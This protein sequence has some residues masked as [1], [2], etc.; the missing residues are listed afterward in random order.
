MLSKTKTPNLTEKPLQVLFLEKD[1][2]YVDLCI[3]ALQRDG[4]AVSAKVVETRDEFRTQL[5]SNTYDVILADHSPMAPTGMEAL[6][7]LRQEGHDAPLIIVADTL[8]EEAAIGCFKAGATDYIVKG[9][10]WRLTLAVRRAVK[11]RALREELARTEQALNLEQPLRQSAKM[12]AVCRVAGGV[13][14]DFNNLLTAI[15]GYSDLLLERL[16]AASQ[17]SR[18]VTEVKKA[19]EQAFSLTRQLLALSRQQAPAPQVYLSRADEQSSPAWTR[20]TLSAAPQG[21]ETILLVEDEDAVRELTR[22]VLLTKGYKV[23]E[24]ANG[25]EALKICERHS[26]P[27]HLMV[28]DVIMPNVSGPELARRLA[29]VRPETKVL[30]TSGYTGAAIRKPE[31]SNL[32]PPLLQ[33]PFNS[34]T[35][36]HRVRDMLDGG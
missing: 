25:E 35:L 30:Y 11:E 29:T 14:H 20:E 27:I 3:H 32:E 5:L 8:D 34:E 18:Y 31:V 26:G 36:A 33:K 4:F 6:E 12:E 13:A 2:R 24:A 7:Y 23:L 28:T 21:S 19:S 1:P 16:P 15:L 9:E 22:M 10:L 17:L